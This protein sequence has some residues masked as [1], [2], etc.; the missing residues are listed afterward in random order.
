MI[1]D[2]IEILIRELGAT[3]ILIVGLYFV[4][5][6]PLDKIAQHTYVINQEVGE[7]RDALHRLTD[8]LNQKKYP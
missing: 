4:L 1:E 7:I 2:L 8:T 5:K 3:G 6:K